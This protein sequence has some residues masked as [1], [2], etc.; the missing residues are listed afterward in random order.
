MV[1]AVI[2]KVLERTVKH[3][4]VDQK[5]LELEALKL[6]EQKEKLLG[7]EI[8]A[9]EEI[10]ARLDQLR[11]LH[12]QQTTAEQV[13][14]APRIDPIV[15]TW[16]NSKAIRHRRCDVPS[17][18][19]TLFGL[20]SP[21]ASIRVESGGKTIF[22][23]QIPDFVKAR[24]A[25]VINAMAGV[26]GSRRLS[27]M[28]LKTLFDGVIPDETRE[29]IV[30]AG[31][32]GAYEKIFLLGETTDWKVSSV[33]QP[34]PIVLDPIVVGLA[35]KALWVIDVFDPTPVEQYVVSEFSV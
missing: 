24:Y 26:C 14:Y 23:P 31:S 27:S 17:P 32:S 11:M 6:K 28:T 33:E 4:A 15:F 34:R 5:A 29:K 18:A 16:R 10:D 20:Q 25:D 12:A 8:R 2:E 35:A 3:S 7:I 19:L 21:E 30:E 1:S 22:E 9:K 13:G